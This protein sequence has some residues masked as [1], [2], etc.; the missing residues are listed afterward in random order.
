MLRPLQPRLL[1]S[2]PLPIA[3]KRVNLQKAVLRTH[4]RLT[5][6]AIRSWPTLV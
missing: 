4:S 3:I 6:A 2:E 1:H 5:T